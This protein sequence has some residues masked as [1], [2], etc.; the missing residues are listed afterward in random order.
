MANS[1]THLMGYNNKYANISLVLF[2]L[3]YSTVLFVFFVPFSWEL[4]GI[5]VFSY[6]LRIFGITAGYHRYFS[7][8]AFKTSRI[9]QFI[10]GWVGAMAMQKGPLWWGAHHRD[11]H[12]YSDTDKDLHSPRKGFWHSHILWF[13]KSDHNQFEIEKIKDYAKYPEIVWLDRYHWVPPTVYGIQLYLIG[14]LIAGPSY[15]FA[16]L[17][18]G[19][20]VSTFF[21]GNGTW[22]INSVTH[23]FGTKRFD[24]GDD[25]RN[26]WFWAFVTMGEGWH[27][28]HHYYR[29]SANMGFYWYE[30]DISYYI[31][32]LFSW[33]GL[34]WGL[35]KPPVYVIEEGLKRDAL[36]KGKQ[37]YKNL[38]G[39]WI[40]AK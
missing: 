10:L 31:L 22:A 25:S 21:V 39:E 20:A 26:H 14:F 37:K 30:Y 17:V 34:V 23:M 18:Y 3:I 19:F 24:A 15:G 38:S 36:R 2:V 35:K 6:F 40:L 4:V 29:H 16:V 8:R 7:H 5:A 11:H 9:M 13:L 28:N 33:F 27:N 12:R 1:S 32:K